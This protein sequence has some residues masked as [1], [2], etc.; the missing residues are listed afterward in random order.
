MLYAHSPK[1]TAGI[2]AQTYRDHILAVIAGAHRRAVDSCD[3]S[4][5]F[6]DAVR[7]AA[8]FHDLGKLDALNQAVL[9]VEGKGGLPVNH[10]DAGVAAMLTQTSSKAA[11]IAALLIYSHHRGLPNFSEIQQN[12]FRDIAPDERIG[13]TK[14]RT[15]RFLREY[16]DA[17]AAQLALPKLS[18]TKN[19]Q[20]HGNSQPLARLALSCLVDADHYDTSENYR[21]AHPSPPVD[22]RASERLAQLDR[23]VAGLPS[24]DDNERNQLRKRVYQSC[25][26]SNVDRGMVACDSPVGSGKTTAVMRTCCGSPANIPCDASLSCF[27]TP[28]SSRKVS[29]CIEDLLCY[30]ARIP[31]ESSPLIITGPN[32]PISSR[33]I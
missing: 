7:L 9:S 11:M 20:T 31:K 21:Q 8:E 5:L 23:Y 33:G 6:C 19:H 12:Q 3:E 1:V 28:T 16:L 22:L 13:S 14:K 2:V 29:M 27:R 17:H 4:G 32:S 10:V 24:T 15:D 18:G 25:H 26:G 30:R